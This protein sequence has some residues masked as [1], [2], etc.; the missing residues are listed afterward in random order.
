VGKS[1]V[2]LCS[3]STSSRRNRGGSTQHVTHHRATWFTTQHAAVPLLQPHGP[4][5][6]RLLRT[7]LPLCCIDAVQHMCSTS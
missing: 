3:S 4:A 1:A 7:V 5:T 2:M 6:L